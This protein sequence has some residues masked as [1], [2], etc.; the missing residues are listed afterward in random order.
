MLCCEAAGSFLHYSILLYLHTAART[1]LPSNLLH[2]GPGDAFRRCT[3]VFAS[4]YLRGFCSMFEPAGREIAH[5][6]GPL[7]HRHKA[8][9]FA[10]GAIVSNEPATAS[11]QVPTTAQSA[12]IS[13]LEEAKNNNL[14]EKERK[15]WTVK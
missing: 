3:V 13:L 5:V 15:F 8:R 14:N 6:P 10:H 1:N 12:I 11:E 7:V 2:R 4:F 9:V